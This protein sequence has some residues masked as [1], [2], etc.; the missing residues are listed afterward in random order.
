MASTVREPSCCNNPAVT[1]HGRSKYPR[2]TTISVLAS[3]KRMRAAQE[4]TQVPCRGSALTRLAQLGHRPINERG[5]LLS[6]VL[7]NLPRGDRAV[8]H[9]Q[10]LQGVNPEGRAIRAVP[11]VVAAAARCGRHALLKPDGNAQPKSITLPM[12]LDRG[13]LV[14]DPVAEM[15]AGHPSHRFRAQHASAVD[16]PAVEQHLAK[17]EVVAHCAESA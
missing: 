3:R 13:N 10:S 4:A 1:A 9:H 2:A 11:G 5:H 8:N 6:V 15:I 7:A 17:A 16:H 12:R 14:L